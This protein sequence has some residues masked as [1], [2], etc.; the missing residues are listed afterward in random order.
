MRTTVASAAVQSVPGNAEVPLVW[1]KRDGCIYTVCV[2]KGCWRSVLNAFCALC[3]LTNA[4][5]QGYPYS[6]TSPALGINKREP[7]ASRAFPRGGRV[8]A[9]QRPEGESEAQAGSRRHCNRS[10]RT[11]SQRVNVIGEARAPEETL[12]APRNSPIEPAA[13]VTRG[14]TLLLAPVT[15]PF[16]QY[17]RDVTM[18]ST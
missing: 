18:A 9:P 2:N 16:P 13:D 6:L 1:R 11:G 14:A 15:L 4:Q 12:Q 10:A 3:Q 7:G 17:S 8:R 5:G